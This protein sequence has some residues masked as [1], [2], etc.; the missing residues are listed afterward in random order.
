MLDGSMSKPRL[1]RRAFLTFVG[2]ALA[3]AG[4]LSLVGPERVSAAPDAKVFQGRDVFDRLLAQARE[5]RW[6]ELPIGE[7]IGAVG[8]ALRQTPYV[9]STLE[10]YDDRE[11]CSVDFRGLDCVT[12]FEL[13]LALARM[14]KRGER[15]PEALLAEVTFLRYRG[16]Q[17]TDYA[18][19]L[20]YLSDWF[21]DN[22]TK[23]VV[24]LITPDL[25]GAERFTHRVN[26]MSRH[27]SAYRQLKASPD[28]VAK[29]A[30][31]EA[32]INAR[33]TY[34]VPRDKV[35]TAQRLLMTG[36]IIGITTTIDGL[37]CSHSGVCYRDEAGVPRL[38]HASTTRNA[39]VLDEAVAT[40]LASVKTHSGIMVARPLSP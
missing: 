18:S 20:H 25:P 10:L 29:I 39:V 19:R 7:R 34:Y 24:R 15:T 1:E 32:E 33:V 30:L 13:A 3:C 14:V 40:Y 16:G 9:A 35:A 4:A 17:V 5:Q 12:F 11:V 38:L 26:F 31:R 8:M 21:F 28:Q 22:Q 23:R 36:D 27:P 37:D 6:S 2:K